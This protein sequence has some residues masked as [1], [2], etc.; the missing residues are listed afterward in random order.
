MGWRF[1]TFRA[2]GWTLTDAESDDSFC[3]MGGAIVTM[4]KVVGDNQLFYKIAFTGDASLRIWL[5]E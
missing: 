2:A 3:I 4:Q 1:S 5:T